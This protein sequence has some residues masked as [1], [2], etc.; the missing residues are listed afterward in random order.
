MGRIRPT[1]I[2]NTG[3][4]ITIDFSHMKDENER[5][6]TQGVFFIFAEYK[7]RLGNL[8]SPLA[9]RSACIIFAPKP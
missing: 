5:R 2:G 4:K 3:A 7:L 6:S 1:I 9:L 8:L